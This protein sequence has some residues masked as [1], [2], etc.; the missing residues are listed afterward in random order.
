VD[1]QLVRSWDGAGQVTT[2]DYNSTGLLSRIRMPDGLATTLEYDSSNNIARAVFPRFELTATSDLRGRPVRRKV[3][4]DDGVTREQW[5]TYD[6]QGRLTSSHDNAG[7][8]QAMAYDL[9]GRSFLGAEWMSSNRLVYDERNNPIRLID[10]NSN[11][12]TFVYNRNNQLIEKHYADGT[13]NR[14]AYDNCGRVQRVIGAGGQIVALSYN[15]LGS[16]TSKCEYAADNTNTPV[17]TVSFQY[18]A[19]AR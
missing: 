12:T 13:T 14:V 17:N 9:L 15:G 18:D 4:G 6:A 2:Y 8:V 11:A 7:G 5:G 10:A 1:G 16:V 19:A 3:V